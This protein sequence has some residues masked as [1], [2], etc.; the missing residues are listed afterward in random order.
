MKIK[1]TKPE[2][3]KHDF[4]VIIPT[5]DDVTIDSTFNYNEGELNAQ[6]VATLESNLNNFD[7]VVD[8]NDGVILESTNPT[9]ESTIEY[10]FVDIFLSSY[11]TISINQNKITCTHN[12]INY[13]LNNNYIFKSIFF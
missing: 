5:F 13:N 10:N 4:D 12:N 1:W 6:E 2:S 8:A 3:S 11:P 9:Y 7:G